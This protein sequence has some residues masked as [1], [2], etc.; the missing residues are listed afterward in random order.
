MVSSIAE[1][2][3][4]WCFPTTHAAASRSSTGMRSY[5]Q[6][7][8]LCS[9]TIEPDK[10]HCIGACVLRPQSPSRRTTPGSQTRQPT[11]WVALKC[12]VGATTLQQMDDRPWHPRLSREET[13]RIAVP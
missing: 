5:R 7:Q 4:A 2:G 13:A 6:L 3:P 9:S 1:A 12:T 10:L 8:C 11:P